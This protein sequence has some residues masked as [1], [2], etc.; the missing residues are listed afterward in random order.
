MLSD[1]VIE[2]EEEEGGNIRKG[3]GMN[4]FRCYQYNEFFKC[5]RSLDRHSKWKHEMNKLMCYDCGKIL[6]RPDAM[7]SIK[8]RIIFTIFHFSTS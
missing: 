4:E 2:T 8:Q 6:S 3:E 5:K 7:K 1:D